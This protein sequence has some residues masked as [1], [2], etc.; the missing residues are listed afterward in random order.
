ME[1][2]RFLRVYQDYKKEKELE[3]NSIRP[4]YNNRFDCL[5]NDTI[6]R[7]SNNRFECLREN[8]NINSKIQTEPIKHQD[9]NRF[10]CLMD[11]YKNNS[12]AE[13]SIYNSSRNINYLPKPEIR[14]SINEQ[15]RRFKEENKV[16]RLSR[17][18]NFSFES[19]YH[20]PE[21]CKSDNIHSE[22]EKKQKEMFVNTT[23]VPINKKITTRLSYENGKL[24][25]K[26]VY[27][28]GSSIEPGIVM[29]KK[30]NYTSWAS[31]I[32]DE[33]NEIIYYDK[34]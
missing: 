3:R 25:S 5:K 28:D 11:D 1:E 34:R 23:I 15:M 26:D 19:N 7:E 18:P 22:S 30:S 20:F 31:V 4:T 27:E 9:H 17:K 24:V 14:E 10:S 12:V 13:T 6:Q 32:K 2:N 8:S 21:L 33:K 29:V 16:I